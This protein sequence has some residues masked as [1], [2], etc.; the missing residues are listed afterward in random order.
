MT[1]KAEQN[2]LD[3]IERE[4]KARTVLPVPVPYFSPEHGML[5]E[6]RYGLIV[7]AAVSVDEWGDPCHRASGAPVDSRRR[8]ARRASRAP[9]AGPCCRR[10][11]RA[12]PAA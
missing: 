5:M 4:R 2:R 10:R 8:A 7:P 3:A 6:N 9:A 1:T 12:C 11:T